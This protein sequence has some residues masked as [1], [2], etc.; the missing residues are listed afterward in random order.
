MKMPIE[1]RRQIEN[2]MIFR[3]TNEQIG[4][5]LD[6][7]DA[8]HLE[9]GNPQLVRTEDIVLAFRCECSDENCDDRIPLALSVYQRIHQER[10]SFIIKP[11]HQVNPI[12]KVVLTKPTYSV[13]KKNKS[14]SEPGSELNE[15][16]IDN[17]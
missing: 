4:T 2:E 7:L 5:D 17:S 11:N 10:S 9:D 13:V 15:T 3:R 8:M 12:E 1:E 16:T 6:A 14:T